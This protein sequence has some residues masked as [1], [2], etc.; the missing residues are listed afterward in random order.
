MY[1]EP[2]QV[3]RFPNE[4]DKRPYEIWGYNE[5]EGGATFVFGDLTG[6]NDY[7]LIH[8]T[9]R[10]EISDTNWKKRLQMAGSSSNDDTDDN[11]NSSSSEK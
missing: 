3:D 7:S 9:K 8:S 5:L 10:G 11:S 1:G 4:N 6:F 2:S